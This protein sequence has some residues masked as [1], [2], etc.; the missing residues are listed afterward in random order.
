[1]LAR[2]SR[3]GGEPR[4]EMRDDR[5]PASVPRTTWGRAA[6][7]EQRRRSASRRPR[8]A[9]SA[10]RRRGRMAGGEQRREARVPP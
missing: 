3:P 10:R 8:L 1:M 4:A 7:V 5:T 9:A 6:R 2:V